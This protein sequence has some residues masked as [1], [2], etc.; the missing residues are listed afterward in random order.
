M[1]EPEYPMTSAVEANCCRGRTSLTTA[2]LLEY[3]TQYTQSSCGALEC[4]SNEFARESQP[5]DDS[6]TVRGAE[7]SNLLC[8]H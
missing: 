7:Y 4:T 6:A 2:L 1:L 3:S 8:N 5:L